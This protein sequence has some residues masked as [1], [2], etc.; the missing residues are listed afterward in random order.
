[1]LVISLHA[2]KNRF[3]ILNRGISWLIS[4]N[5]NPKKSSPSIPLTIQMIKILKAI[6]CSIYEIDRRGCVATYVDHT[7]V[8]SRLN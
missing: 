3:R 4:C 2:D 6:Y 1:M 7:H 5:S 8:P